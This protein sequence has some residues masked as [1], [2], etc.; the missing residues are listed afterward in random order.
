[1]SN[2]QLVYSFLRLIMLMYQHSDD[3]FFSRINALYKV[4]FSCKK[5]G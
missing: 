4:S 1:M 5:D 2:T 3:Y